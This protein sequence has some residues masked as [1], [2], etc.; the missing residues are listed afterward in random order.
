MR[1]TITSSISPDYFIFTTIVKYLISRRCM[2]KFLSRCKYGVV[3]SAN[4]KVNLAN[5][6][7]AK[8]YVVETGILSAFY[9]TTMTRLIFSST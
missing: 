4:S 3:E 5:S 1:F 9:K 2:Y 7:Y 8:M 6:F